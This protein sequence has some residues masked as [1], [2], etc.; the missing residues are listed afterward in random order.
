MVT[1]LSN[2]VLLNAF[3]LE[4]VYKKWVTCHNSNFRLCRGLY[5]LWKGTVNETTYATGI[6]L[7]NL[8]VLNTYSTTINVYI[9]ENT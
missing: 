8:R 6:Q 9:Y 3:S 2:S 7:P 5:I 1:E 4:P